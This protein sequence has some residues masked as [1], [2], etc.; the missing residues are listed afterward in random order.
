MVVSSWFL[1][2]TRIMTRPAA[3]AKEKADPFGIGF[4]WH[5]RE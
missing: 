1:L 2:Q 4:K 5:H 3:K